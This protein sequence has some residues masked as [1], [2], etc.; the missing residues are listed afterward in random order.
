MQWWAHSS[1]EKSWR[2]ILSLLS[3]VS[4][5]NLYWG[6]LYLFTACSN[7]FYSPA[8]VWCPGGHE[9]EYHVRQVNH[10]CVQM[11]WV[12]I[13]SPIQ[14]RKINIFWSEHHLYLQRRFLTMGCWWWP[15][16]TGLWLVSQ[17]LTSALVKVRVKARGGISD[18]D[19]QS[20]RVG[21]R[22]WIRTLHHCGLSSCCTDLWWQMYSLTLERGVVISSNW[23]GRF[24]RWPESSCWF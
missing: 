13:R 14:L 21:F 17:A 11:G 6:A 23:P 2:I 10:W 1:A 5:V 9:G 8:G 24:R 16:V 19:E 15:S 20:W 12:W 4:L 18:L 3:D 7:S 22:A